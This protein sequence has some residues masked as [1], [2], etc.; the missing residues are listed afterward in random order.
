VF[1]GRQPGAGQGMQDSRRVVFENSWHYPFVEER[2][3][4]LKTLAQFYAE[5]G[6][7]SCGETR[8]YP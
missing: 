5:G 2:E 3:L 6:G 1:A 8:H 7:G 4:F